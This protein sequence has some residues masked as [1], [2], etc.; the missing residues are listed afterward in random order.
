MS[1]SYKKN[2]PLCGEIEI[3]VTYVILFSEIFSLILS[4]SLQRSKK[5]RG[6]YFMSY[7]ATPQLVTSRGAHLT[8]LHIIRWSWNMKLSD[9]LRRYPLVSF[10]SFEEI[11]WG[12]SLQPTV[13]FFTFLSTNQVALVKHMSSISLS[14]DV[15]IKTYIMSNPHVKQQ[16][17]HML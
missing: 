11:Y 4:R 12:F 7:H 17:L 9:C 1:S 5:C 8:P 15:M 16:S 14:R 13:N 2:Y 3:N 6:H 10:T